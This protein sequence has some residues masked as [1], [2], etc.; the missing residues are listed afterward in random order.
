MATMQQVPA[1]AGYPTAPANS[2]SS[3][4]A[5]PPPPPPVYCIKYANPC[6]RPLTCALSFLSLALI[7]L[8]LYTRWTNGVS[9]QQQ[10]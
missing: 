3:T 8:G 10:Q 7:G 9:R 4:P 6:I 5:P 1:A 2:S